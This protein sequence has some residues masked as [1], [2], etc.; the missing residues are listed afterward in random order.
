MFELSFKKR[1]KWFGG[2]SCS[3]EFFEVGVPAS[4]MGKLRFP[5]GVC[6]FPF[7]TV[8]K[9]KSQTPKGNINLPILEAGAPTSK[10]SGEQLRPPNHLILFL[11]ESSRSLVYRKIMKP[12]PAHRWKYE[13]RDSNKTLSFFQMNRYAP[14]YTARSTARENAISGA[15]CCL[16]R[17]IDWDTPIWSWVG[18]RKFGLHGPT[19][20]VT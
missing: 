11:N 16:T 18:M 3:P 9:G 4:K 8:I 5:L 10:N 12:N 14:L 6:D 19:D 2:L 17:K 7:I 20:R 13:K 15:S 1:I